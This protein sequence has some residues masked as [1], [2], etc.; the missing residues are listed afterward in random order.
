MKKIL[1]IIFLGGT[2]LYGVEN[3]IGYKRE[4]SEIQSVVSEQNKK[5]EKS[6]DKE[7]VN[8]LSRKTRAQDDFYEFVN[9]TW[10][11]KTQIPSTKPAWGALTELSEENQKF[12][13]ALIDELKKKKNIITIFI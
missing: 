2:I 10:I 7:M 3:K 6:G 8:E 4:T 11:N 1:M 13:K 9:E 5:N 12:L